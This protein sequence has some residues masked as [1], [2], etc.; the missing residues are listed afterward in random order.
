METR[1]NAKTKAMLSF[2]AKIERIRRKTMYLFMSKVR[3]SG[4]P[5]GEML[6]MIDT[7]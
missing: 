3:N 1:K 6:R 5:Y 7:N 2:K 4:Q